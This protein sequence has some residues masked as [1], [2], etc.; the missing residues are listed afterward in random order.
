MARDAND[1]NWDRIHST[2]ALIADVQRDMMDCLHRH[3]VVD[4]VR[5]RILQR[6]NSA[7]QEIEKLKLSHE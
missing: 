3:E 2:Q 7:A 4:V 6:L 5:D 1:W